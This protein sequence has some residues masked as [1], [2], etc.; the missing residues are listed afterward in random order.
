MDLKYRPFTGEGSCQDP[1]IGNIAGHSHDKRSTRGHIRRQTTTASTPGYITTDDFGSDGDDTAHTAI[2]Y[3]Y[4]PNDLQA[5]AS[6][7]TNGSV[8]DTIDLVFLDYIGANYIIPALTKAAAALTGADAGKGKNYTAADFQYYMP[9]EFTTNSY[10]PVYAKITPEWQ[11]DV[12]SC[13]V[14]KGVGY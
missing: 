3:Y 4:Q 11:A 8:P 1:I 5:N 2:P 14:G 7:P 6:F 13:P 10:L 9:I 12:P